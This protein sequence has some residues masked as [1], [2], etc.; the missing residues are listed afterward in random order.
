V[1]VWLAAARPRTL[2]AAVVPVA[3]GTACA[4]AARAI[5]WGPALAALAGALAIQIGTNFANDVYDAERGA[6]GPDRKGPVRAVSAGLIASAAMKR[7]MVL[8]FAVAAGFGVY[9]A[10]VAGWPVIAIGAAAIAAGVAYTGGPWPLGYHGLG[11]ACVLIAFGPVA[12]CGTAYVQLGEVPLR[13]VW[14]SLP[15]G[16]LATAILVV[17]NLRD[18]VSDARAGKR[19]LAVRLGR[20][21]ALGEYALLLAIAY[22][23]PVALGVWPPVL[24]APL[25]LYRLRA[26]AA[27]TDYN[28]CLAATAGLLAL[29]G[30]LF[31]VGLCG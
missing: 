3:V 11:D 22:V 1:R 18:R 30:T 26:L 27:G 4:H 19:T 28:R 8:A 29:H 21:A 15:V 31:A 14:A 16:A 12:V 24:T 25:A 9:L 13:A 23:V 7:A 10:S 2:A 5:A 20:A 17:N 6:D